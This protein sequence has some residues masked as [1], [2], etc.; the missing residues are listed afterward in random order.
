MAFIKSIEFT[1]F[2]LSPSRLIGKVEDSASL[3]GCVL[4]SVAAPDSTSSAVVTVFFL[5]NS[6]GVG[7]PTIGQTK[8]ER[9]V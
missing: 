8:P 1:R 5:V 7:S 2:V 6:S 4:G 9:G 3:E